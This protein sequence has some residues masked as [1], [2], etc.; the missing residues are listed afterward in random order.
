M[1]RQQATQTKTADEIPS[2]GQT[3][4]NY[5]TRG[6]A[7]FRSLGSSAVASGPTDRIDVIDRHGK[8]SLR[9][10]GR[11]HPPRHRCRPRRA[12]TPSCSSPHTAEVINPATGQHLSSH[13]IDPARS[14][15]VTATFQRAD[16]L[17]QRGA[18]IYAIA[19]ARRV[20]IRAFLAHIRIGS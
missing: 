14:A 9:P 8:I 10:A 4:L 17:M 1:S 11:M 18:A 15:Q 19:D 20:L 3:N 6:R 5:R 12:P 16:D 2:D 7:V 13:T